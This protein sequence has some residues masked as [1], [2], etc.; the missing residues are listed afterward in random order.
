MNRNR[1]GN[2]LVVFVLM[3]VILLAVAGLAIDMSI[4]RL[5][6]IQM[7]SATDATAIEVLTQ[8]RANA[9]PLSQQTCALG[10]GPN[11]PYSGG[12]ALDN[13]GMA[14]QLIAIEQID[15]DGHN[16][17]LWYP[18]PSLNTNRSSDV[19][20]LDAD[21][22]EGAYH[23]DA[24][25]HAEQSG[26]YFRED[27]TPG[28]NFDAA[29]VRLRRSIETQNE[30]L[31][32]FATGGPPVPLLFSKGSTTLLSKDLPANNILANGLT[33]RA[34]S[35]AQWQVACSIMLVVALNDGSEASLSATGISAA[36]WNSPPMPTTG[37]VITVPSMPAAYLGLPVSV[38][39]TS[40][41]LADGIVPIYSTVQFTDA[42]GNAN[43][44]TVIVGFV[45][46]QGGWVNQPRATQNA[47][48]SLSLLQSSDQAVRD[49]MQTTMAPYAI[50]PAIIACLQL[51][52]RTYLLKA[53]CLVRGMR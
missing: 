33:V 31:G 25:S 22:L 50:S 5:S 43:Q 42:Q 4:A 41:P 32:E 27:F 2:V 18:S 51:M 48:T 8:G 39:Q 21:V 36:A 20:N 47:S 26:S 28:S 45:C 23:G 30:T 10:A 17:N 37:E 44:A 19:D 40:R 38:A 46:Y 49:T 16:P 15:P 13:G 1:S 35:I 29:L 24:S 11:V 6:R 14:A 52:N 7:Q 34:T 12:I 9:I 3:S 53:P